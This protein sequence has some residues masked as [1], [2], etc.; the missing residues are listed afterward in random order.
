MTTEIKRIILINY[1]ISFFQVIILFDL[2]YGKYIHHEIKVSLGYT[3]YKGS[4]SKIAIYI[5]GSGKILS[6]D[7]LAVA[8]LQF[9]FINFA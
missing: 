3:C 5:N 1:L 9:S 7:I 8:N 4:T 6:Y 2:Y